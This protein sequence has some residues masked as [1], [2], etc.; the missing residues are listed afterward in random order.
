M[1]LIR[2]PAGKRKYDVSAERLTGFIS[3]SAT[4]DHLST[5]SGREVGL[6]NVEHLPDAQN[7]STDR[8]P[9]NPST[10]RKHG[11]VRLP[12]RQSE[13]PTLLKRAL[14]AGNIENEAPQYNKVQI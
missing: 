5:S 8:P 9:D 11:D 7:I 4:F 2:C 13:S 12:P 10:S 6:Q 1:V 3:D 14:P